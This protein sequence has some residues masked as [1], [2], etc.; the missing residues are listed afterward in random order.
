[1]ISL[2]E[3]GFTVMLMTFDERV[4]DWEG[5]YIWNL[6]FNKIPFSNMLPSLDKEVTEFCIFYT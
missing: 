6:K 3:P 5:V 2:Y 4:C 1:M